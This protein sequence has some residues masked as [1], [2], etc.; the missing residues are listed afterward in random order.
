VE[1]LCND[2]SEEKKNVELN[3]PTVQRHKNGNFEISAVYQQLQLA[4]NTQHTLQ[5]EDTNK[6]GYFKLIS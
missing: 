6:K 1:H 4:G 2:L 5:L 3:R